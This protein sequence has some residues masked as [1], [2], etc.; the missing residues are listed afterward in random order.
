MAP[1]L[2]ASLEEILRVL[3]NARQDVLEE[4]TAA[5]SLTKVDVAK[6]INQ[7]EVDQIKLGA[8]L[9][10]SLSSMECRSKKKRTF[11]K[12]YMQVVIALCS[13]CKKDAHLS[14]RLLRMPPHH[15]QM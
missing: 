7:L 4:A 3:M 6:S 13:N 5:L 14:M 12:E 11:K 15:H 9:K 8:T 10:Q 2:S 1:F